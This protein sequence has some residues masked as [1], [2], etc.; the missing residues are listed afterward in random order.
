MA[1]ITTRKQQD[2]RTRT[3]AQIRLKIGGQS[4]SESRTF[5]T[6]A[7][8]VAWARQREDEIKAHPE[9]VARKSAT[10]GALIEAYLQAAVDPL[11]RSKGQHLRLLTTYPI[12]SLDATRL[13][14]SGRADR[15][16]L[17]PARWRTI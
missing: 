14:I 16:G 15:P 17:A 9:Q 5:G 10:I 4:Y 7:A 13:S 8:A 6:R 3:T 12:A 1:A 2:G 11:G